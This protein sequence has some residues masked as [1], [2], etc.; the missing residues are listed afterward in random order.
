MIHWQL[1]LQNALKLPCSHQ[2]QQPLFQLEVMEKPA[3]FTTT[4]IAY[5][6]SDGRECNNYQVQCPM[7]GAQHQIPTCSTTGN[8]RRLYRSGFWSLGYSRFFCRVS[9]IATVILVGKA[10]QPALHCLYLGPSN[11][12]RT[13]SESW[14]DSP[15]RPQE[16]LI[17]T[18]PGVALA[19]IN[20]TNTTGLKRSAAQAAMYVPSTMYNVKFATGTRRRLAWNKILFLATYWRTLTV[21]QV[22]YLLFLESSSCSLDLLEC[23]KDLLAKC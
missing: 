22:N 8:R 21:N 9:Y 16:N 7:L 14:N 1:H 12:N 19:L 11:I 20:Q 3:E 17:G 15:S 23:W 10:F 13:S 4:A 2:R 6:S 18:K 5:Q